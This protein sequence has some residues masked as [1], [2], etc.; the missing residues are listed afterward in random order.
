[1]ALMPS[2]RDW[3]LAKADLFK[4]ITAWESWYLLGISDI[5]LRYKRSRLGQ[6]WITISMAIFICGI[7]V[8]YAYLFNQDVKTYLPYLAVNFI[9][10]SMISGIVLDSPTTFTQASVYMTQE[11]LPRSVF[12]LR[13]I[14]RNLVLF[15]HNIIII[16]FIFVIFGVTPKLVMLLAIPGLLL[17]II[18]GF[19]ATLLL[20]LITTR[21][22][23]MAQIL[24][25]IV[26][27][28]FFITPVMWRPEQLEK[29]W[30]LI[31]FNPFAAFLRLITDPLHGNIPINSVYYMAFATILCLGIITLTVFARFRARIV[32]WL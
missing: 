9:V 30:Y 25:N 26:Q 6:F 16:P 20:A 1:M 3:T 21:F 29:V 8:V 4:G 28:A 23:D 17:V 27:M 2:K 24:Q 7:G 18:A 11:A 12:A 15:A 31:V 22:R 14:V 19:F 32:Y 13:I 5:R 10:W